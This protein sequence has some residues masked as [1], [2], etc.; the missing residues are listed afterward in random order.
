M[1]TDFSNWACP[2]DKFNNIQRTY[3]CTILRY[4]RDINNNHNQKFIII[5]I[6]IHNYN[7]ILLHDSVVDEEGGT[8]IPA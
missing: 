4:I 6:I 2:I 3:G 1:W 7:A 8:G 5:I